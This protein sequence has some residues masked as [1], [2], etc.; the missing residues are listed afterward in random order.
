MFLKCSGRK[1][2]VVMDLIIYLNNKSNKINYSKIFF[3][4]FSSHHP[5]LP[6]KGPIVVLPFIISNAKDTTISAFH[7]YPSLLLPSVLRYAVLLK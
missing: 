2:P 4:Y 3:I 6:I 1:M 5:P 7:S